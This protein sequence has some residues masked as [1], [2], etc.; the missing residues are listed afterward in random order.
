[1]SKIGEY[2]DWKVFNK[3]L[4]NQYMIVSR[5]GLDEEEE[6]S[7]LYFVETDNIQ[8]TGVTVSLCK[9]K[10]LEYRIYRKLREKLKNLLGGKGHNNNKY[11]TQQKFVNEVKELCKYSEPK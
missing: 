6:G 7:V 10:T 11:N 8:D 3:E 2:T 9:L 4:K 5:A 1:M